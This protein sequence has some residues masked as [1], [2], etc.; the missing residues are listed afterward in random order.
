V[1]KLML[2]L[3]SPSCARLARRFILV[4][5]SASSRVSSAL[6]RT[7]PLIRRSTLRR[8]TPNAVVSF[9]WPV[10]VHLDQ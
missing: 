2:P 5:R 6:G 7:V 8:S 4:M 1:G 3:S 10:T 9:A